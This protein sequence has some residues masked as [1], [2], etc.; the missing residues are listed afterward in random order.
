MRHNMVSAV[1]LTTYGH[2]RIMSEAE[3]Y[4]RHLGKCTTLRTLRSST[5]NA[6]EVLLYRMCE[7][8]AHYVGIRTHVGGVHTSSLHCVCASDV[9]DIVAFCKANNYV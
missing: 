4:H 3:L 1:I 6:P 2:R 9:S 8:G 7:L 5:D